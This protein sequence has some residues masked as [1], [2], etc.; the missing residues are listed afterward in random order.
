MI[1]R[2]RQLSAKA[3]RL[4]EIVRHERIRRIEK[5]WIERWLVAKIIAWANISWYACSCTI[6]WL[7][8]SSLSALCF[9][10]LHIFFAKKIWSQKNI[11]F[12]VCTFHL[13]NKE[14]LKMS[15]IH[16]NLRNVATK[17]RKNVILARRLHG[18]KSS[19]VKTTTTIV[20]TFARLWGLKMKHFSLSLSS[21][22]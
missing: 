4:R 5:R 6:C 7:P 19:A 22:R 1:H 11:K 15:T 2:Q 9:P 16:E 3:K 12:Y 20:F 10:L 17:S 18:R 14:R 8:L 13:G 21:R